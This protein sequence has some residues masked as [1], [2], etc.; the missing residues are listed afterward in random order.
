[1]FIVLLL[2][3][4]LLAIE[5][6]SLETIGGAD[7]TEKRS[8]Q[9]ETYRHCLW[10]SS[11]HA[12]IGYICTQRCRFMI[13]RSAKAEKTNFKPE[14]DHQIWASEHYHYHSVIANWMMATAICHKNASSNWD[15]S[16]PSNPLRAELFWTT[17]TCIG[18]LSRQWEFWDCCRL[19]SYGLE[20]NVVWSRG[21]K[22]RYELCKVTCAAIC[23]WGAE[24]W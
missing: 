5:R 21:S 19:F 2:L 8:P 22:W 16:S 4:L 13:P 3:S 9:N 11:L 7:N 12:F 20:G 17:T 6:E 10:Y 14:F 24:C 1:M 15:V 23:C 18:G